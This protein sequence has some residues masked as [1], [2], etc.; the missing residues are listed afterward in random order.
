MKAARWGLALVLFS[1][2]F[3][4]WRY[5]QLPDVPYNEPFC[6]D[7]ATGEHV[8]PIVYGYPSREA[9]AGGL[10]KDGSP[11]K[12]GGCMSTPDSPAWHCTHC[13]REWGQD[14]RE[15]E[16]SLEKKNPVDAFF[17]RLFKKQ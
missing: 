9:L 13:G 15:R 5:S 16:W 10:T 1:G 6:R 8:I 14:E 17:C 3:I 2:S 11:C 7:C 4:F 12:H